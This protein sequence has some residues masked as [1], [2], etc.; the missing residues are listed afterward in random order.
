MSVVSL[1]ITARQLKATEKRLE[2]IYEAARSGLKGDAL[3]LS[4]GLLPVEFNRLSEF[5]PMVRLAEQKG[6][7]DA[8]RA[9]AKVL[10]D[11]AFAGDAKVA[12]EILKHQHNWTAAQRVEVSVEQRISI[13]A[14]LAAAER[15]VI[16]GLTIDA[17][18]ALEAPEL[19]EAGI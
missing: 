3:A 6:R 15:R 7:A 18:P 14:A 2:A 8:E 4:A 13:T 1:P 12:L 10:H 19:A 17:T 9:L 5:D 11:A 16:E